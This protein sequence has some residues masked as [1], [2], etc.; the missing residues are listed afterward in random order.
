MAQCLPWKAKDVRRL[1]PAVLFLFLC[2]TAHAQYMRTS[3]ASKITL[4]STGVQFKTLIDKLS[5][6]TGLHFI[7]SSNK[8]ETSRLVSLSVKDKPLEE[9]LVLLGQQLN[10]AFTKRDKYVIIKTIDTAPATLATTQSFSRRPEFDKIYSAPK[11]TPLI[12]S[13]DGIY[14]ASTDAPE[15][16]AGKPIAA[17][18]EY[19]RKH[20]EDLRVY[21]DTSSLKRLPE[22]ELKKVNLKTRHS[23]WF[24]SAGFMMNDF[25]AGAELQAG[26]RSLYA[27]YNPAWLRTGK[28][29]GAFG[30]GTSIMLSRNIAFTPV[31]TYGT[32]K[33]DERIKV[34]MPRRTIE[35]EAELMAKLHQVRFTFQYA[36][37]RNFN[38]RVGPTVSY[39]KAK[40]SVDKSNVVVFRRSNISAP[41][42][43][44]AF[45]LKTAGGYTGAYPAV[46]TQ[47]VTEINRASAQSAVV[48][49]KKYMLG[50]EASFSYRL[51][52]FKKR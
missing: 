16:V 8:I 50:W 44:P 19:F 28:Y 15:P 13:T 52:F 11:Y 47:F 14:T 32:V 18:G 25:A 45:A 6:I 41:V 43:F 36:I 7:Y 46:P 10:V 35:G 9:V 29:Y 20:L 21:F 40:Y 3:Y 1:I 22:Y 5:G 12:A 42:I 51:N 37:T 33:Q 27:V 39:M 31:Y 26:V 48:E 24:I 2:Q 17:S 38:V 34:N 30:F 4:T 49:H 23:G